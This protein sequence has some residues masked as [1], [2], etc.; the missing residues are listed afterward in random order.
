MK[1]Y[2]LIEESSYAF[3]SSLAH[4]IKWIWRKQWARLKGEVSWGD[5]ASH[6]T[7]SLLYDHLTWNDLLITR[8]TKKSC[9]SKKK[10]Q[11]S[12]LFNLYLLFRYLQKIFFYVQGKGGALKK[13]QLHPKGH[14]NIEKEKNIYLVRLLTPFFPRYVFPIQLLIFRLLQRKMDN[15]YATFICSFVIQ[16]YLLDLK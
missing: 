7:N 12:R 11:S 15:I 13:C 10:K 8:S 6:H 5:E 9:I 2:E 1:I 3:H 14:Y 16:A 4:S